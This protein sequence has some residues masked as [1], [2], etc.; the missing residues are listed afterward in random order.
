MVTSGGDG[1]GLSLSFPIPTS[2]HPSLVLSRFFVR[3]G[4][5]DSGEMIGWHHIAIPVFVLSSLIPSPTSAF[6]GSKTHKYSVI[7]EIHEAD[8]EMTND[9]AKRWE[10]K[11]EVLSLRWPTILSSGYK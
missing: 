9:R 3:L 2:L 1:M 8:N 7:L 5:Q 11:E 10:M 4:I 6:W